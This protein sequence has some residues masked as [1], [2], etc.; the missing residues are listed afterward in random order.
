MQAS[1]RALL[2]GVHSFERLLEQTETASEQGARDRAMLE[3]A[4]AAGL[5]AS[6]L[7][8]LKT[9]D[10]NLKEGFLLCRGKGGRERIVPLGEAA[11]KAEVLQ[12]PGASM[13]SVPLPEGCSECVW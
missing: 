6:E 11:G 2:V 13:K 1:L 12:S 3:V 4:Y 9:D 7:V 5:R 10:L 8:G